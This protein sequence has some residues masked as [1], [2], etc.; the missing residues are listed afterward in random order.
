MQLLNL[1]GSVLFFKF[2]LVIQGSDLHVS[3]KVT[4]AKC[5]NIAKVS[6][7]IRSKYKLYSTISITLMLVKQTNTGIIDLYKWNC[8]GFQIEELETKGNQKELRETREN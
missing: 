6:D 5:I 8:H 3:D 1:Q 2:L 7:I 4:L